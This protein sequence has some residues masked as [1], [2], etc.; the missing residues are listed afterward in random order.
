MRQA[1][2]VIHVVHSHL[3][4]QAL[5]SLA[6]RGDPTPNRCHMLAQAEVEALD[7]GGI[8]LPA[9]GRQHLLHRLQGAKHI[10]TRPRCQGGC[11]LKKHASG[12]MQP[13]IRPLGED[14]LCL[15][16]LMQ[17][18]LPLLITTAASRALY[19]IRVEG[20]RS[21]L[22]C[23]Q[24]EPTSH[25][26]AGLLHFLIE[27]NNHEKV[28]HLFFCDISIILYL[29]ILLLLVYIFLSP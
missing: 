11:K 3:L 25:R 6:E 2:I 1:K 28:W 8:D 18:A 22:S 5:L 14:R 20:S 16:A 27:H 24:L 10:W 9:A 19:L 4:P 21:D 13:Y 17:S 29:L 7:E 12:Q 15:R 26:A 23:H